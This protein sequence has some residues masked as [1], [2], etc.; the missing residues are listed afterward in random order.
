MAVLTETKIPATV[1][2]MS[3]PDQASSAAGVNGGQ[4]GLGSSDGSVVPARGQL[5]IKEKRTWKT[6]QLA[7]GMW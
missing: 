3:P 5:G 1:L 2:G 6:W 4:P 7:T